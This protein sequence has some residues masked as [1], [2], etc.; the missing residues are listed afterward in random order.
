VVFVVESGSLGGSQH[1]PCSELAYMFV[2]WILALQRPS[3]FQGGCQSRDISQ[4]GACGA[5]EIEILPRV[6]PVLA[7][8]QAM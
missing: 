4:T 1:S 8:C 7:L 3:N 5:C 2:S 6:L